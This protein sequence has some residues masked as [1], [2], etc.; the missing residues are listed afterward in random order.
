MR[1]NSLAATNPESRG[2]FGF[3][4]G[5]FRSRGHMH[6]LP[7]APHGGDEMASASTPR[8]HPERPRRDHLSLSA[9]IGTNR[10][11]VVE[12]SMRSIVVRIDFEDD[13]PRA[14]HRSAIQEH[15]CAHLGL[16]AC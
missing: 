9:R 15:H 1:A 5:S 4:S 14:V 13:Q 8:Q 7:A 2:E 12:P 3:F 6:E 16:L 11:A 10:I